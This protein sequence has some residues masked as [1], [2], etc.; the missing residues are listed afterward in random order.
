MNSRYVVGIGAVAAAAYFAARG[1][2]S[3]E[4]G[5]IIA[6]RHEPEQVVKR[7]WVL[8]PGMPN[9]HCI[10]DEDFILVLGREKE[11]GQSFE[12]KVVYVDKAVYDSINVGDLFDGARIKYEETD[13]DLHC[14]K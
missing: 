11:R 10:D 6:K 8:R 14:E 1:C 13:H 5:E 9:P 7:G 2:N 12:T 3:F 4:S